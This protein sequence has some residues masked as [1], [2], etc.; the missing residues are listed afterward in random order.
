MGGVINI[1]TKNPD[2]APLLTLNGYGTTDKAANFDFSFSPKA[3]GFSTLFSG[4]THYFNNF[5]DQN[6]DN[7]SDAPNIRRVSLFNKWSF[8]RKDERKF[9]VAFKYLYEERMGGTSG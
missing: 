2:L 8:E 3:E 5:L 1:R 4:N 6:N 9:D 7:F